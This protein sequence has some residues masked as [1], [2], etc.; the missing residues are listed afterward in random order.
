MDITTQQYELTLK[1]TEA[2][3]PQKAT[4][5]CGSFSGRDVALPENQP[6]RLDHSADV[7]AHSKVLTGES[8][9]GINHRSANILTNTPPLIPAYPANNKL[10][11]SHFVINPEDAPFTSGITLETLTMPPVLARLTVRTKP[12]D[13]DTGCSQ[14]PFR[15]FPR[16]KPFDLAGTIPERFEQV[17]DWDEDKHDPT[18]IIA[19]GLG[20]RSYSTLCQFLF[21]DGDQMDEWDILRASPYL[22]LN[23][24]TISAS[25]GRIEKGQPI[26]GFW[27]PFGFIYEVPSKNIFVSHHHDA[28]VPML[29]AEYFHRAETELFQSIYWSPNPLSHSE[30]ERIYNAEAQALGYRDYVSVKRCTDAD[31]K[32]FCQAR[33]T[34]KKEK[35]KRKTFGP[36]HDK[37]C[38]RKDIG[39]ES[40]LNEVAFYPDVIH[41]G[42]RSRVKII[43]IFVGKGRVG[44]LGK[45]SGLEK[46]LP[47]LKQIAKDFHLPL[48]DIGNNNSSL[49]Q[50]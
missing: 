47:I 41:E 16:T 50:S 37:C 5:N 17:K 28:Y 33:E 23:R 15:T 36:K 8:S 42:V 24:P 21:E 22:A 3:S 11:T 34:I 9:T 4:S 48:L 32:I 20:R 46:G 45:E 7:T 43:G 19:G 12:A 39:D 10:A 40:S 31:F 49:H 35:D 13:S 25:Y 18:H 44:Y 2:L 6:A 14:E 26:K 1:T 27:Y 30:K 38:A 29:K